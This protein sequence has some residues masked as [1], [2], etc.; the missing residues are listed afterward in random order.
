MIQPTL[1]INITEWWFVAAIAAAFGWFVMRRGLTVGLYMLASTAAGMM[2]ADY[3][4]KLLQPWVNFTYQAILALVH[5][6]AFSP[7]ALFKASLQEPKLITEPSHMVLF[8]SVIFVLLIVLA[9]LI[10]KRR[11]SK[12]PRKMTRILAAVVGAINGYLVT[13]FLFPR[14]ITQQKT[15]ITVPNVNVRDLLRIQLNLPILV[16]IVVLITIGVL[17]AR[18]GKAKGK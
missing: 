12:P 7:E 16:A 17:G 9:Y 18:E 14:H 5:Q 11:K 1:D 13:F 6:R 4:A 15:I 10:G 2:L 3:L 8:G